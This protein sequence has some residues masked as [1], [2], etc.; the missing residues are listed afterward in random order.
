MIA[1]AKASGRFVPIYRPTRWSNPFSHLE[2]SRAKFKVASVAEA[3]RCYELWLPDQL[4]LIADLF[5][6]HGKVL[7]CVCAPRPC[8]GYI[9]ARLADEA[10]EL[11]S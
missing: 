6:L 3:L 4:E 5:M 2:Y 10:V 11:L 8:H 7:G 1:L 9:L